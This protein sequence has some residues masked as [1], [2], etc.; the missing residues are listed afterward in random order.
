MTTRR[1]TPVLIAILAAALPASASQ[2]QGK[3]A[4]AGAVVMP[5]VAAPAASIHLPASLVAPAALSLPTNLVVP[6]ASIPAASAA[7]GAKSA[8][9]IN[10]AA[11][12]NSFKPGAVSAAGAA[13][14]ANADGK[15]ADGV[16][17]AEKKDVGQ[18][19]D[20]TS[21][22][23]AP[24]LQNAGK[25]EG[26]PKK[27]GEDIQEILSGKRVTTGGSEVVAPRAGAFSGFTKAYLPNLAELYPTAH[28][29]AVEQ[30]AKW[31]I[32]ED[33]VAFGEVTAS[34]PAKDDR[35]VHYSFYA[36]T[37]ERQGK[38]I[39]I[40]FVADHRLAPI[41][42]FSPRLR[43][44]DEAM[45]LDRDLFTRLAGDYYFKRGAEMTPSSAL[46]LARDAM[47][48]LGAGVSF[49]ARYEEVKET[50]EVDLW[51]RFYDDH[52]NEVAVNARTGAAA[53][54]AD[55]REEMK[56][57]AARTSKIV[58]VLGS[59]ASGALIY[60]LGFAAAAHWQTNPY[61]GYVIAWLG[62][63]VVAALVKLI[64]FAATRRL[65]TVVGT[66]AV[67]S[68]LMILAW[69]ALKYALASVAA[70]GV[71]GFGLAKDKPSD[72]LQGGLPGM[73]A[74]AYD[75]AKKAA[76]HG[77]LPAPE[78]AAVR[79]SAYG[80]SFDFKAGDRLVMAT[81]PQQGKPYAYAYSTFEPYAVGKTVELDA[82][83]FAAASK[84]KPQTAINAAVKKLKVPAEQLG[85]SVIALGARGGR[86]A[87]LWYVL[88]TQDGRRFAVNAR[89]R[90][91][92]TLVSGVPQKQV[93]DAARGLA[94]YKGRPWS[95]TE[96][97]MAWA[98]TESN[99]RKAGATIAQLEL[100]RKITDDLPVV[101]GGFNSW[102]GD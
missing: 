45:N 17:G 20:E 14:A 101:G 29:L 100:F 31:G 9:G 28:A 40:T 18:Q 23:L 85:F 12:A 66:G 102:S 16:P 76:E 61:A 6:G 32:P 15:K 62:V 86:R 69:V 84:F 89:T 55:A 96:Y 78:F 73:Y 43:S 80:W 36:M 57:A 5:V 22:N 1:L 10:A 53:I 42:P 48:D 38:P 21:A 41:T 79:R 19:L 46:D 27:T 82:E 74:Q 58:D 54:Q 70:A 25:G 56:A 99:L 30:A 13:R 83:A 37:G 4:P 63:L 35:T 34:L 44:F 2:R 52:G 67:F 95:Q 60:P 75:A 24:S 59:A 87:E 91:Y 26:D 50:G 94:S 81:I 64:P 11:S 97:N 92:R 8:A 47:M 49:T 68:P 3:T 65:G 72:P 39:L 88:D 98:G 93:E 7:A 71:L 51:Y 90:E 77:K 33:K